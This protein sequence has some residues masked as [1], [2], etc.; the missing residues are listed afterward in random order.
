MVLLE[1]L[2]VIV[3]FVG[4]SWL[5]L[6]NLGYTSKNIVLTLNRRFEN[7]EERLNHVEG[8]LKSDGEDAQS[9]GNRVFLINGKE[10]TLSE[11]T[12]SMEGFPVEQSVLSPLKS[13]N[14]S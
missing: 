3:F 7:L 9:L 1:I 2:L 13:K 5:L 8:V 11:R 4:V 10:Y 14:K 6:Y 12:V